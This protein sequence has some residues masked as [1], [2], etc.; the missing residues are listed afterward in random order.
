VGRG[1]A[2][3]GTNEDG[4]DGR[5]ARRHALPVPSVSPSRVVADYPSRPSASLAAMRAKVHTRP[6]FMP[7]SSLG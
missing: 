6:M 5:P 3:R 1:K 7:V 4:A 2:A